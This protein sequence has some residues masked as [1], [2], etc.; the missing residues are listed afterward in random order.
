MVAAFNAL[1][2]EERDS[3]DV[4]LFDKL[5]LTVYDREV[6]LLKAG[7]MSNGNAMKQAHVKAEAVITMPSYVAVAAALYIEASKI[8]SQAKFD[9]FVENLKV[10]PTNAAILAGGYYNS[11]SS[12]RY[13]V[14]DDKYGAELIFL[15]ADKLSSV[16]EKADSTNKPASPKS[17]SKPNA[18]KFELGE[19]DPEYIAAYQNYLAYKEA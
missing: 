14:Y 9:A 15:A 10:A 19:A 4:L 2:D 6:A 12:F 16:T 17:V 3:L 7:G 13:A 18:S 1:T 5:L 11:Y 8:N